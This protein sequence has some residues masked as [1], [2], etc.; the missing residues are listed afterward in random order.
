MSVRPQDYM[1]FTE[2]PVM[3]IMAII[4][5]RYGRKMADDIARE[6]LSGKST[7]IVKWPDFTS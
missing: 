6:V 5:D 4:V 7:P 1:R 3:T 2:T